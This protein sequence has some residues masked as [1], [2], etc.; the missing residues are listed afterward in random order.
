MDNGSWITGYGLQAT[1]YGRSVRRM[2]VM[3]SAFYIDG[4]ISLFIEQR[5]RLSG[6]L[7]FG[8]FLFDNSRFPI[9]STF[10]LLCVVSSFFLAGQTGCAGPRAEIKSGGRLPLRFYSFHPSGGVSC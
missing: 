9:L 5:W 7:Q 3:E 1:G 4:G 10:S 2:P 8:R 6:I